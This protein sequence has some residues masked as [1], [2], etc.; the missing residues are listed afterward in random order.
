[1]LYLQAGQKLGGIVSVTGDGVNDSPA[2]KN[3]DVG[4]AMGII[5]MILTNDNFASIVDG[6]EEGRNILDNLKKSIAYTLSSTSNIPEIAP[7]L[8]DWFGVFCILFC[9]L[10]FIFVFYSVVL[11]FCV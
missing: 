11:H 8:L 6:G 10:I 9:F 2:L 4:V 1:M 5:Y 7:F 3:A